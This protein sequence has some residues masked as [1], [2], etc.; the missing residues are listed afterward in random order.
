MLQTLAGAAGDRFVGLVDVDCLLGLRIEHPEDF[1]DVV[2]HLLK[3]VLGGEECAGCLAMLP[4]QVQ[5]ESAVDEDDRADRKQQHEQ[6]HRRN[7]KLLE[8]GTEHSQRQDYSDHCGN[9]RK[10]PPCTAWHGLRRRL[11]AQRTS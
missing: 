11:R 10:C 9:Y 2:R 8:L 7:F 1:L 4:M 3:V 6:Q 5:Q